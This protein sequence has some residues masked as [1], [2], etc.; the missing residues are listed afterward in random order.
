MRTSAAFSR[1]VVPRGVAAPGMR[2]DDRAGERLLQRAARH[3]ARHAFPVAAVTGRQARALRARAAC[4]TCSLD[5]RPGSPTYLRHS[6]LSSTRAGA[7]RVY[8]PPG[9]AHGFQTLDDDTRGP[10]HDDR[11]L[12]ARARR[13][14]ALRR[15]EL[16]HRD[17]RSPVTRD[18]RA[19]R[20]LSGL[21]PR[22]FEAEL[23][24]HRGRVDG[25][26]RSRSRSSVTAPRRCRRCELMRSPPA[27]SDV[28]QH[29]RRRAYAVTRD[30]R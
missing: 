15:S 18:R 7:T 24:L 4:S 14:R 5:L 21:R 2:C 22:A 27:V 13:R 8:I 23:A 26:R 3:A 9:V 1:A 28:P 30:H 16:R 10:V 29:H 19:R 17:G 25:G 12:R 11:G 6:S 20:E